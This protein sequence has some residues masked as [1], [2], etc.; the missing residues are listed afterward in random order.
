MSHAETARQVIEQVSAFDFDAIEPHIHE[1]IVMEAPYQAFHNGPMRRGKAAFME[2]MRFVP[3]VFRTFSLNIHALYDSPEQSVV[4][5]EMTSLGVFAMGGGTY[6][7]RYV[8]ILE[9]RDDKIH[10][11]REFFNPEVMNAGMLFMLES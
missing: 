8:L 2:G 7:N 1:D 9:F 6:Q 10:L 11:W 4:V 5:L 3:N